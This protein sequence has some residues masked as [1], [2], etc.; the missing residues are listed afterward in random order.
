MMMPSSRLNVPAAHL[1]QTCELTAVLYHPPGHALHRIDN[2][3]SVEYA[4]ARQILHSS[5]DER[6]SW[7][8]HLPMEHLLHVVI[9]LL[10]FTSVDHLPA[11]HDV[12]SDCIG[13]A[14]YW[15]EMQFLHSLLSLYRPGAQTHWLVA[16]LQFRPV[17]YAVSQMV[18]PHTHFAEFAIVPSVLEHGEIQ[19]GL[20]C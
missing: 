19:L 17:V 1:L 12:H 10:M 3:S 18:E 7:S 20:V 11:S 4:P 13:S 2:P 6:F 8:D 5:S 15:P 9:G 16:T 14:L